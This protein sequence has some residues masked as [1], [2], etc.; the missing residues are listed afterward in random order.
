MLYH[1]T[2]TNQTKINEF[3]TIYLFD[4]F[5]GFFFEE[6]KFTSNAKRLMQ[7]SPFTIGMQKFHSLIHLVCT[8]V[9]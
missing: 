2:T 1:Q 4:C 6:I 3:K 8:A 7:V 5:L 9:F